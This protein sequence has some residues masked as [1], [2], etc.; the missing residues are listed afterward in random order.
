MSYSDFQKLKLP[1]KAP[2]SRQGIELAA[3]EISVQSY[4][5]SDGLQ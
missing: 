3:G 4:K 1:L 2:F 5:N